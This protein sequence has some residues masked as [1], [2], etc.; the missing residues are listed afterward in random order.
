M[1]WYASIHYV[2]TYEPGDDAECE[3]ILNL[4]RSLNLYVSSKLVKVKL[5]RTEKSVQSARR[6]YES[7]LRDTYCC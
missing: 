5:I 1:K 4:S 6:L 7:L 2:D 3:V